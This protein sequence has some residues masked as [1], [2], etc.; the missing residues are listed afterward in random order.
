MNVSKRK[1][2]ITAAIFAIAGL[3]F[4]TVN[5]VVNAI[6]FPT[7]PGFFISRIFIGKWAVGGAFYIYPV[8]IMIT[9]P[10]F[11]GIIGYLIGAFSKSRRQ[12]FY[13][14]GLFAI[15]LLLASV[16]VHA[17][18]PYMAR[19]RHSYSL[20]QAER[21]LKEKLETDPNDIIALHWLGVHHLTRTGQ[22]REAEKY[23]RQVVELEAFEGEFSSYVQRSLI[24]LAIIYQSWREYDK[25]DNYYRQFIATDPDLEKDLVL[26]NYNKDYLKRKGQLEER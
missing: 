25:A 5:F 18:R 6:T 13:I 26:L 8:V 24:Y 20:D 9:N 21:Q 7:F 11:Y 23:F 10:L 15:V 17:I 1:G 22:Y 2:F 19:I 3:I 14:A 12:I 16:Y 4:A